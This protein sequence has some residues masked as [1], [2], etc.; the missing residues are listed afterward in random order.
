MGQQHSTFGIPTFTLSSIGVD[1]ALV[2]FNAQSQTF[3]FSAADHFW[4]VS[5]SYTSTALSSSINSWATPLPAGWN[6]QCILAVGK[7]NQSYLRYM[8]TRV[9]GH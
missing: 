1:A 7:W 5:N 2:S 8:G 4:E 6:H 9:A 3:V